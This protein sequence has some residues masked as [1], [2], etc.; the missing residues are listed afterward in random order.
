MFK[1][2]T[3][4]AIYSVTKHW[5]QVIEFVFLYNNWVAYDIKIELL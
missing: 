5:I 4:Q 1:L 3:N 2:K